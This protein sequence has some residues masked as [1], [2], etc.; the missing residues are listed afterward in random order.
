[1][2]KKKAE[3][4]GATSVSDLVRKLF[5]ASI[6]AAALAQGEAEALMNRLVDK[7]Q[8]A[9]EDGRKILQEM[10]TKRRERFD[11]AIDARIEK[12]LDRLN[13]PTKDDIQAL[14]A[15]ISELNKKLGQ[16]KKAQ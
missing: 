1:M 11:A 7:G 10:M 2:A 9:Q 14:S 6:G 15:K 3:V 4:T 16:Q 8:I 5:L 12:A 13:V